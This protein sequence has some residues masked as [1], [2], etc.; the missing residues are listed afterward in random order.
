LGEKFPVSLLVNEQESVRLYWNWWWEN[1]RLDQL[2]RPYTV[3]DDD[4][5]LLP[6]IFKPY[7]DT[8][9]YRE[10]LSTFALRAQATGTIRRGPNI[11]RSGYREDLINHV[12]ESS[13]GGEN[14]TVVMTGGGYGAGKTTVC[15]LMV[16]AGRL[17][18]KLGSVNGVDYFKAYLP[19][20]SLLQ[21]LSDGRAST[22]VQDEAR[23]IGNEAF[24]Q[25][26]SKRRSFGW[27][28]S[29]SDFDSTMVRIRAARETDY[30]M[31]LV[32]VLAPVERAVRQ[33]MERARK[34]KRFAHPDYLRPSHE[35]F[36]ANLLRYCEHFDEVYVF[37][38][39]DRG[40]LPPN[41][42][43]IASKVESNRE[44]AIHD[45]ARFVQFVRNSGGANSY[46]ALRT[47]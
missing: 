28:S 12:V 33:A 21:L 9:T 4:E 25:M 7:V 24:T 17:G 1:A 15:D 31:K 19:E 41:P 6:T 46:T 13:S 5:W 30:R 42:V 32:A 14:P 23:F 11:T 44:L 39:D 2:T 16:R 8:E 18:I 10:Y 3:S 35:L 22:V 29:M 20:F 27:D 45:Y 37:F 36:A 47:R 43:L 26:I 40:T 34:S 38:N